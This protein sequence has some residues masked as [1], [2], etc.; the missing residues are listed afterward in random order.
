MARSCR[1]LKLFVVV[2]VFLLGVFFAAEVLANSDSIIKQRITDE[3]TDTK[4]LE[5]TT[6]S[7]AVDGGMVILSGSVSLYHQKMLYSRI[8]WRT[9]DVEDVDNEIVVVPD[10]FLTDEEIELRIDD[11]LKK[12]FERFRS[13]SLEILVKKGEVILLGVFDLPRDVLFLKHEIG[14]INGVIAI[15]IKAKLRV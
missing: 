12:K 4:D 8:A 10:V 15:E 13:L 7:V 5:G 11:I 2:L 6:I 14:K 9:V 1:N 3:I